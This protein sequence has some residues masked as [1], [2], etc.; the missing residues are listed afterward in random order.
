MNPGLVLLFSN[1]NLLVEICIAKRSLDVYI[2]TL[3]QDMT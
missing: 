1:L 2:Y 3:K